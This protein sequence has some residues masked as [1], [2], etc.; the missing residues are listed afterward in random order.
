MLLS[1]IAQLSEDRFA[2]HILQTLIV[3]GGNTIDRE[4]RGIIAKEPQ[5]DNGEGQLRTM[6]ELL[7]DT[8]MVRMESIIM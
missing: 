5:D 3:L 4:Q 6:S 2:S 7:S 1:R 8:C